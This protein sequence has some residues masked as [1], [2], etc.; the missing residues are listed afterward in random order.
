MVDYVID[1][2]RAVKVDFLSS[3]EIGFLKTING[4]VKKPAPKVIFQFH[5]ATDVEPTTKQTY[6]TIVKDLAAIKSYASGIMVPK[7]YI[8]P[9]KPDKYL[10]PPSTLVADAHKLGL[11]VYVYGF[12]NDMISNYNY[13]YDPSMEYLQ[14]ISNSDSVDGFITDFP[15][16]ASEA[17]GKIIEL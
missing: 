15:S 4:L 2:L 12:A 11:E 6:G 3:A 7:D 16:T 9:V 10:G 13:S 1:T 5:A 17:V 14:F 8:W